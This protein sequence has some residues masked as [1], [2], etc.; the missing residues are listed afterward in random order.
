MRPS[1]YYDINDN[2]VYTTQPVMPYVSLDEILTNVL[3]TTQPACECLTGTPYVENG[4]CKCRNNTDANEPQPPIKTGNM[5]ACTM[6][7]KKCPDGTYVSRNPANGCA[8]NACPPTTPTT[9]NGNGQINLVEKLKAN[10]LLTLAG[11]GVLAYL[12]FKK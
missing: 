2:G 12:I 7:A 1:S 6:D 10:P 3:Q 9:Q 8:F 11:A 5:T 4:V